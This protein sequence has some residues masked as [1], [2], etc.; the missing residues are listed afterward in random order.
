V[1]ITTL[2]PLEWTVIN[3]ENEIEGVSMRPMQMRPIHW[4]YTLLGTGSAAIAAYSL[5]FQS[6][7]E[8]ARKYIAVFWLIAPPVFFFFEYYFREPNLKDGALERF[9]D[10]QQRA[11]AIWVGVAAALGAVYFKG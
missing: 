1:R 2:Q 11:A 4:F 3:G 5:F 10:M 9:K 6:A 7:T 8:Q